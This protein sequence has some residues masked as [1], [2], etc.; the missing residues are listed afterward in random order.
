MRAV[1]PRP[2]DREAAM[3]KP[4]PLRDYVSVRQ[5]PIL[6]ALFEDLRLL[7]PPH[8]LVLVSERPE[9][10]ALHY[11]VW[12]RWGINGRIF[13][14]RRPTLAQALDGLIARLR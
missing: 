7:L 9:D 4:T 12:V 1:R 10:P 14:P 3:S 8:R 5:D 2:P 6:A 11:R 13:G